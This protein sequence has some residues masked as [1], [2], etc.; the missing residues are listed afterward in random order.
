MA[1]RSVSYQS[2]FI[3]LALAAALLTGGI[4]LVFI[5]RTTCI[6]VNC[7]R[8]D[9][10]HTA[11]I[12]RADRTCIDG[13]ILPGIGIPQL[14]QA[15]AWRAWLVA[16]NQEDREWSWEQFIVDARGASVRSAERYEFYSLVVDDELEALMIL[17]TASRRSPSD[18]KPLVYVEY[19]AVA[20]H[21]RRGFE[22]RKYRYCGEVMLRF[23]IHRSETLRYGGRVG[24]HSL[25]GA[26]EFYTTLGLRDH[27]PDPAEA[28]YHYFETA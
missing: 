17:H 1:P 3:W 26:R 27:G 24:L 22:P 9:L 25:P 18:H 7:G 2:V 12:I 16:N 28:G 19:L 5:L 14:Q 13:T 21:G 23:A 8:L 15:L 4:V 10:R 6:G 11:E 20:P